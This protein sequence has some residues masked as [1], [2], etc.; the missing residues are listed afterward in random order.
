MP[1]QYSA[2]RIAALFKKQGVEPER[3]KKLIAFP[4]FYSSGCD[5]GVFLPQQPIKG[6]YNSN[7][8]FK[9]LDTSDATQICCLSFFFYPH[10][11]RQ[12]NS[13]Q[14]MSGKGEGPFCHELSLF[15]K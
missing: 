5:S 7:V 6:H 12:E 13:P 9:S 10:N 4:L 8:S 11:S 1:H 2:N 14:E 15:I 3:K